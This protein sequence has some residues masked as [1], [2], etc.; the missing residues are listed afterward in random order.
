MNWFRFIMR[1]SVEGDVIFISMIYR[2][3]TNWLKV[4]KNKSHITLKF[5]IQ[6]CI[7]FCEKIDRKEGFEF[8]N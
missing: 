2:T 7:K 3:L 8:S 1:R 5:I 6:F 4:Q